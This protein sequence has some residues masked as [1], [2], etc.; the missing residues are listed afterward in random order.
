MVERFLLYRVHVHGAGVAVDQAVIFPFPVLPDP[1]ETPPAAGY[2]T[3]PGAKLALNFAV[4]QGD[5]MG[6][7]FRTEKALL[8]SLRP[9]WGRE[10][11]NGPE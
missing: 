3:L 9:G 4:L 11:R 1:A 6:R 5:E 2:D 7:E 8:S 10:A